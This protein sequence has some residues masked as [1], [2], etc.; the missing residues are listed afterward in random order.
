MTTLATKLRLSVQGSVDR[1]SR[2]L[3]EARHGGKAD[4]QLLREKAVWQQPR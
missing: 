4:D 3:D 2:L 1:K